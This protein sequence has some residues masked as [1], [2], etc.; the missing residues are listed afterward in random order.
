MSNTSLR[1]T[2]EQSASDLERKRL[3][4]RKVALAAITVLS[5]VGCREPTNPENSNIVTVRLHGGGKLGQSCLA[6]SECGYRQQCVYHGENVMS[7]P[8]VVENGICE[9]EVYPAGCFAVLPQSPLSEAERASA[10]SAGHKGLPVRV[11]CQ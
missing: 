9:A 5:L 11:I 6:Q 8:L 4:V 2:R 3:L 7:P 1:S 10:R